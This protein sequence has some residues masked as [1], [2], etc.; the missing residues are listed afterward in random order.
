MV[1]QH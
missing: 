1:E